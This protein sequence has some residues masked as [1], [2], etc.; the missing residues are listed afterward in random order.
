[1]TA[2]LTENLPLLVRDAN[3]IN[4]VREL[5]FE[6]AAQ[7]RLIAGSG[8]VDEESLGRIATFVMGQAPPGAECNKVGEGCIFVKTGEFGSLYPEVREWTTK[9]LK[10]AKSGDV[11]ICVVGAT[12]GKLN[13]AIDCAIGRSVAAIRP[14]QGVLTRYLYF[15]LIP[16]TLRLR[17]Q[18]RGSA[19]GVIG[20]AEL[21]S[22]R[23]R[24]PSESEQHRIVAKIEELM[25]LCDALESQQAE[26]ESAH[27][28]LV[29]A[30]LDSLTQAT[31]A[32][33]FVASWQRLSQHFDT[34]FTTEASLDALKQ[35]VLQLAVRGKLVPQDPTDEPASDFLKRVLVEKT[36]RAREGNRRPAKVANVAPQRLSYAIPA[37]WEE[38]SLGD[39]VDIIRGIT[40]PASEKSKTLQPGRVACLRTANIQA[41]IEWD[42]LLFI[43]ESFVARPEQYV[44]PHDIVMSMA[45]S[46]E[47]VG[48]VA[49][50]DKELEQRTTFGGFLGVLRTV[51]IEPRYVMALLRTPE[52]RNALIDSSS[53][54]TNIANVSLARLRPLGCAIPPVAEQRRIVAKVDELMLICDQLQVRIREARDLN[55]RLARILVECAVA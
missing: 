43:R 24:L 33:D 45:N 34:L 2:L 21:S 5:I 50:V 26:A 42:D 19:Q 1:V 8:D 9:P 32:E 36:R 14:K 51:L 37:S 53:Q 13:L 3:G 47:L 29:Q 17:R 31:D 22:V 38:A 15:S 23:I 55:Q 39:V 46:R 12:V 41:E 10:F 11:L 52:A 28:Q 6:L 48:K 27:A 30:L 20:K 40:F 25:A 44:Q 35:A 16:F 7:G 4:K 49:L 18:S 54:T